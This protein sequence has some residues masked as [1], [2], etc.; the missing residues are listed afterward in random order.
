MEPDAAV[1]DRGARRGDAGV[2]AQRPV[3]GDEGVARLLPVGDGVRVGRGDHHEAPVPGVRGRGV[4]GEE[5]VTGRGGVGR[6]AD[7]HRRRED[8]LG[9]LVQRQVP[10]RQVD[11]DAVGGGHERHVVR[12][13]PGRRP[14]GALGQ[15]HL[16]PPRAGG[17]DGEG[18][19]RPVPGGGDR[20]VT[21]PPGEGEPADGA[22]GRGHLRGG[23]RGRRR[24]R[25]T[26]GAGGRGRRRGRRGGRRA[27]GGRRRRGTGPAAPPA[28]PQA[29]RAAAAPSAASTAPARRT[30]PL[31]RRIRWRAPGGSRRRGASARERPRWR[32]SRW[33]RAAPRGGR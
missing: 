27:G 4:E 20:A 12:Q 18:R 23:G 28:C 10:G 19:R 3:D 24:G 17:H 29:D 32:S 31:R 30:G 7:A 25:G 2:G 16:E 8:R 9:R 11:H 33:T 13:N 22:L 26:G 15:A 1:G 14:V 5:E 6:Q 21:R